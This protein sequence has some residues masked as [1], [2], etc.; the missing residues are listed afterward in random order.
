MTPILSFI[1]LLL[2]LV[3]IMMA[4]IN[5]FR[6]YNN[7]SVTLS[8]VL[9]P[10]FISFAALFVNL[11]VDNSEWNIKN[12]VSGSNTQ[13]QDSLQTESNILSD[14]L[15]KTEDKR[16]SVNKSKNDNKE[17]EIK[18]DNL[19]TAGQESGQ[20]NKKLASVIIT[21]DQRRKFVN[22]LKDEPKGKFRIQYIAGD[23]QAFE[24]SEFIADMLTEAG[25]TLSG[26]ISEFPG[27]PAVDGISIVINR[28]ETEPRYARSIFFAFRSI[29]INI[30]A[31]RN[32]QMA[33]PLEVL[34][35]VGHQK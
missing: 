14:A 22:Y 21:P 13:K 9:T 5:A 2:I 18:S 8:W 35:T 28:N 24:Y 7:T 31:E 1:V 29:G 16:K 19:T 4:L 23:K 12:F 11:Y 6:R 3:G 26:V 27:N 33:K 10:L 15:K 32:K 25:Y 20:T 30:T 34:I 17:S